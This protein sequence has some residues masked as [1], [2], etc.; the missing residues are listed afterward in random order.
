MFSAIV[1]SYVIFAKR[2][3][4]ARLLG[5]YTP[6]TSQNGATGLEEPAARSLRIIT[7]SYEYIGESVGPIS[8]VC[9]KSCSVLP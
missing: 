5:G 2:F 8:S 7:F 1:P 4:K 6:L 3:V 9:V